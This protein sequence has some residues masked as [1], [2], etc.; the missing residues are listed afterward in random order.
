MVTKITPEAVDHVAKLCRIH[1]SDEE[2]K[3]FTEQLNQ[4][5][6]YMDKLNEL[7]TEDV[8][9]TSHVVPLK[10]VLRKDKLSPSLSSEKALANAPDRHGEYFKVPRIIN[11]TE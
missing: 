11:E 5:L 8:E 4:I 6:T 3:K 7:N 1:L 2:R 10:N 9:P